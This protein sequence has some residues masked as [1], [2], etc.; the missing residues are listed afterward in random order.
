M[1]IAVNTLVATAAIP[2]AHRTQKA[3]YRIK[4]RGEDPTPF[5]PNYP[6]QKVIRTGT[7]ECQITVSAVPVAATNRNIRV[8]RQYVGS[9]RYHPGQ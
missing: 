4:M 9:S 6:Y 1:D 3:V 7:D 2:N 5:F 8:D